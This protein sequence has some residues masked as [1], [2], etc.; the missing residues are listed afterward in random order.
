MP[1]SLAVAEAA[2]RDAAFLDV[3]DHVH[4]RVPRNEGLAVR[5]RPG[6]IELAEQ[7]AELE[8]LR[9]GE[10]LAAEADHQIVEPSF[11]Y[12][13]ERIRGD[14]LGRVDAAHFGSKRLTDFLY[15]DCGHG[16]PR[17]SVD[18]LIPQQIS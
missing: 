18:W 6:R 5:I 12:G 4:L 11:T 3:G 15:L 16:F 14:G 10:L 13:R 17:E 1:D 8:H 2:D 7:P 9:I